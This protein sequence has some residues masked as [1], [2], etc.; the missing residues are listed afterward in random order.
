MKESAQSESS[1]SVRS[2]IPE[3]DAILGGGFPSGRLFLVRG[4]PGTGK[5]TLSLQFLLEGRAQGEAGVYI[6]LSETREELDLV[7]ASHGWS[8]EG[9]A[10]VELGIQQEGAKPQAQTTLLHPSEV[11]LNR[12]V[13]T[14]EQEVETRQPKRVALDSLA[15]LR[16]VA[17]SPLRYHRQILALKQFFSARKI[18]AL[19]LDD[20]STEATDPQV[21]SI[22]HGV[23]ELD[24]LLPDY[25][26]DRRRLRVLKLR[27]RPFR[28]GFHDFTIRKGGLSVFPRLVAAEH[29]APFVRES[30]GSGVAELDDLLG[31][32][33]DRGTSTLF[34]GPAGSGK[35]TLSIKY[36]CAAAN[37]GEA[38][39]M[40]AFDE[41]V[42]TVRARAESL[43]I[44]L[45]RHEK[46]GRI[47]LRQVDPAE[48]APG[49][50][51][52]LVQ[53]LVERSNA[54]MIVID[55][56]NGYL[57]AMPDER[58]VLIQ[59]HELLTFLA[60]RGVTTLLVMAQ[61][62]LVGNMQSP[63]DLTYLADSVLMLR[64][65]EFQGAIKK[66]ISV[67]KKRSGGHEDTIR[68]FLLKR[69]EGIR[70]GKPLHKFR[71]VLTGVPIYDGHDDVMLE[72]RGHERGL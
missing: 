3:L 41:N 25:G 18:T 66:A 42:G 32:G 36:A 58:F 20:A 4:K 33:L 15:E 35:S 69:G 14:L 29:H 64:Y 26:T 2:G 70:I 5:T 53:E 67:V 62:G 12:M 59:L 19:F 6:T 39:G 24:M 31:G 50:F 51:A 16:L 56:L 1:P 57:H 30:I 48:L 49:E 63:V 37:R 47:F 52:F 22:A 61:H 54:R 27:G 34:I 38:V 72:A 46:S 17:Q 60:Q 11:E 45:E 9:I 23:I 40:F 7:A 28:G 71:G 43:G 13:R 8:L 21:E 68:E 65:F 10:I 55:S 44:D